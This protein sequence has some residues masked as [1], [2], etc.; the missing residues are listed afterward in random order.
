MTTSYP[1]SPDDTSGTFVRSLALALAKAVDVA[2]VAPGDAAAPSSEVAGDIRIKRF[3]YFW[4]SRLQRL[5]YGKGIPENLKQRPYLAALIPTFMASFALAA[6]REAR[7][8]DVFHANWT[9][10][11][12]AAWPA[13]RLFNVPIVVTLRGTD[14]RDLPGWL[15]R[16]ILSR[17]DR[18]IAIQHEAEIVKELGFETIPLQTPIDTTRYDRGIDGS[19]A[20][21]AI[22]LDPSRPVVSLVARLYH[23]KDPLTAVEAVP[24]VLAERPDVQFALVGDGVLRDEVR[25]RVEELGIGA[26]VAVPGGRG[27]VNEIL[28]GS[29]VFLAISPVENIW[30]AT[31]TE[32]TAMGLPIVLTDAGHTSTVFTGD[33]NCLMVPPRNPRAVADAVL[34]LVNDPDLAAE[35]AAGCAALHREYGH[36]PAAIVESHVDMY[37]DVLA[38]A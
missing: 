37:R 20:I 35:I 7:R 1:R 10:A 16:F 3:S 8:C 26:S 13:S 4:P 31:I 25:A 21:R 18:I 32:A 33:K 36:D 24:L 12:L 2:V 27:D 19:G 23:F 17:V 38:S 14:V 34:R 29:D 15:T 5:A 9:P 30:S 11:A 28:A 6:I 22:G